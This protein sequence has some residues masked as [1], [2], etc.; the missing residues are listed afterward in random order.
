VCEEVGLHDWEALKDLK[1]SNPVEVAEYAVSAKLVSEPCTAAWWVPFT[2]KQRD[3]IV[4][5]S[6]ERFTKEDT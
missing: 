3:R 1:E 4:R 6:F 2:L 5:R